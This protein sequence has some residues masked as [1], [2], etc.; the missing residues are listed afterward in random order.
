MLEIILWIVA[1]NWVAPLLMFV[2]PL[3]LKLWSKEFVFEGFY[4]PFAKFRLA[5]E[6]TLEPWHAKMWKDW[7]G[8]GLFMFMCY[9]DLPEKW[10]DARVART[11]VHEGT[12]C[13]HWLFFGLFFWFTYAGHSLWILVTQKIKGKPYTKHSYLDIW[14][15]R[16]ARKRAGQLVDVPPDQWFDGKDDIWAWW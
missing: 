10:D 15:E 5:N 3:G 9:R 14:S 1:I 12:H 8:V 6:D 7:G 2:Y 13:W 4:G 16:L 11:I